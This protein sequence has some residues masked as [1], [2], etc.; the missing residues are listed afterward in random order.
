MFYV[1]DSQWGGCRDGST[2]LTPTSA[3]IVEHSDELVA[4]GGN[5]VAAE[6]LMAARAAG[7]PVRF[8]AADMHHRL[9]RQRA[10]ARDEPPP[11]DFRGAA[12]AA[13]SAAG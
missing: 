12:H 4:I 11:D 7:K 13:W 8:I 1:A 10:A 9:A 2:R 6:E 5:R 3:A